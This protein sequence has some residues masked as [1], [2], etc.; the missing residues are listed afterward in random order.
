M[1]GY[2]RKRKRS[3]NLSLVDET[4]GDISSEVEVFSQE[5]YEKNIESDGTMCERRMT[6]EETLRL[7]KLHAELENCDLKLGLFGYE[8]TRL[9]QAHADNMQKLLRKQREV[10]TLRDRLRPEYGRLV[11]LIAEKYGVEDSDKMTFDTESG[12][13]RDLS[14]QQT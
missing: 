12:I 1:V 10:E 6:E 8:T 13:I 4:S 2:A 7:G 3:K 11:Q 14:K 5:D 9:Q